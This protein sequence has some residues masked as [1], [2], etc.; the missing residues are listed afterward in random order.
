MWRSRDVMLLR[1]RQVGTRGKG[2]LYNA[3]NK[4]IS[5]FPLDLQIFIQIP[6]KHIGVVSIGVVSDTAVLVP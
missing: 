3:F 5:P 2:L 1:S 6:H 4:A